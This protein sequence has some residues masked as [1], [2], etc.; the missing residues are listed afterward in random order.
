MLFCEIL[1]GLFQSDVHIVLRVQ[2]IDID[3]LFSVL[4]S[5]SG[6]GIGRTAV[7]LVHIVVAE[8]GCHRSKIIFI[9]F[10]DRV[11]RQASINLSDDPVSV[12][13]RIV[14]RIHKESFFYRF[15]ITAYFQNLFQEEYS[16]FFDFSR[17][18]SQETAFFQLN[19]FHQ[20]VHSLECLFR[21]G[22]RTDIIIVPWHVTS[23]IRCDGG[24]DVRACKL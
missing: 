23:F 12:S 15:E 6:N 18:V 21:G 11:R 24:L 1:S 5:V 10:K 3:D 9:L 14:S 7:F 2:F 13:F 8:E 20:T 19:H 16:S 4:Q 17:L 22:K